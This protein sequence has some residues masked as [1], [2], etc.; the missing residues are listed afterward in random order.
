VTLVGAKS[1]IDKAGEIKL[2]LP[3][4]VHVDADTVAPAL[5]GT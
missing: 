3:E 4:I 5:A 2:T 1:L